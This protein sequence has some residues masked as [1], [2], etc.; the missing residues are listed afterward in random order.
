MLNFGLDFFICAQMTARFLIVIYFVLAI[1][2]CKEQET[3]SV[4]YTYKLSGWYL[5]D[6]ANKANGLKG[7]HFTND[8][9]Y[10]WLR[11]VAGQ[12]SLNCYG[13]YRQT[14]DSTLLWNETFVVN[15]KITPIDTMPGIIQ[16][17]VATTPPSA[18]LFG[19]YTRP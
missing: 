4:N 1:A 5:R 17:Q 12:D 15:F 14:S 8:N 11:V 19:T 9:Q 3:T 6:T 10:C 18:P 16:L 13:T 2:S 7:I